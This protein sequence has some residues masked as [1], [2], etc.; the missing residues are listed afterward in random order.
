MAN[1]PQNIE[2]LIQNGY[3]TDIGSYLSRGWE[4]FKR[5]VG[6][7]IGYA[8]LLGLINIGFMLLSGVVDWGREPEQSPSALASLLNGISSVISIPL[9]A[10]FY[11]VAFK[12]AKQ[13]PTTFSDFFRGFN[14]FLPLL[15]ATIVSG[16]LTL[17]GFLLLII[18]GIY[19]MIAYSFVVPLI[20]ERKMD[21]WEAMETSRKVITK[22]WFAF[23][24]L[25][26]L[27]FL[28][29]LAGIIPCGLGL[30]LTFPLTYCTYVAAYEAIIGMNLSSDE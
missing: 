10:G 5:N 11:I 17:L 28:I 18:P 20:L 15:L 4:L 12:L 3:P 25:G 26:L 8:A 14:Y 21:F 1:A 16:I 13:R 27:M 29:N 23:L 24:G 30:L 7:F 6:G 2:S 19:L 9:Q 22:Q